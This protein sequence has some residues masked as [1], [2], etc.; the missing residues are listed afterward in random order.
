MKRIVQQKRSGNTT[1][2]FLHDLAEM[3]NDRS[4]LINEAKQRMQF[5]EK[6][7][8]QDKE[9]F[10]K[11]KDQGWDATEIIKEFGKDNLT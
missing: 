9:D 8:L 5:L 3:R 4:A 7:M 6:S 1:N 10:H 11:E 2:W